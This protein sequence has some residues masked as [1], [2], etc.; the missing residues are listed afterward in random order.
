M[1]KTIAPLL[2]LSAKGKF[3][4]VLNF[5]NWGDVSCVRLHRKPKS[6][7]DPHTE[8]Q[9]F[10][11]EYYHDIVKTWQNL[12][13]S[14]KILLDKSGNLSSQSGFN[15]YVRANILHPET[16]CGVARL[17]FSELGDLTQ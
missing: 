6:F 8:K 2:S 12:Q 11:R 4:R 7:A 14:E 13:S 9:I 16:D 17:G 1:A 10:V 3:A 5:K 15:F